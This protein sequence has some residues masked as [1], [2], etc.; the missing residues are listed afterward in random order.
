VI[1]VS[2]RSKGRLHT[3][4]N[5]DAAASKKRYGCARPSYAYYVVASVIG[6]FVPITGIALCFAISL[7][8]LLTSRPLHHVVRRTA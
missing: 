3:H 6:Y 5:L 4:R 8:A 2:T 7:V 1:Q